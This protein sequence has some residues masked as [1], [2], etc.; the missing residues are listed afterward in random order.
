MP[1]PAAAAAD[2]HSSPGRPRRP[3]SPRKLNLY[4]S[5]H[6]VER[7]GLL[8]AAAGVSRSEIVERLVSHAE[9]NSVT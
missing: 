6:A 7:L 5:S 8:A 4:L 9:N 2:S 3:D 1:M